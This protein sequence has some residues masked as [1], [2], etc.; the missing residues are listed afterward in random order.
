MGVLIE[1]STGWGNGMVSG[2]AS[3]LDD[4]G[5]SWNVFLEP[6]GKFEPL[7]IPKGWNGDGI[8]ARVN[9]AE[10]AEEILKAGI[11]CVNVS[12]YDYG[13]GTIAR[14]TLDEEESGR[15]A[16]KYY[17]NKKYSYFAYCG[18]PWRPD[19]EDLFGR[20]Y[21]QYLQT[22][23]YTC[24]T[25]PAPG[26]D[27]QQ[28]WIDQL[29]QL[30]TWLTKL[31]KPCGVLAIDTQTSRQLIDAAKF[32]ELG[33]PETIAVLAGE[34]DELASGI[35]RPK[36]SMLDNA[37]HSVGYN[38]A[39]LL[40]RIMR[41]EANR[42]ELVTIKPTNV[43]SKKSTDWTVLSDE[44]LMRALR[45]VRDNFHHPIQVADLAEQAGISRRLLEQLFDR[46]LEITPSKQILLVRLDEAKHLLDRSVLAMSEI[47]SRCGFDS[48]EVM[49]RAFQREL[50]LSPTK[51]RQTRR[52]G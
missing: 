46:H 47:A 7:H 38:A 12:W 26:I 5:E 45:F 36:L 39:Q 2:I 30:G 13:E 50:Q 14:C 3:Y 28:P 25:Y 9:N 21:S 48:P 6:R 29:R 49:C 34:H 32:A 4:C 8:I 40:D 41:G 24:H 44:R 22:A 27:R 31:P 43:I 20:A 37:A 35:T 1:T 10:L 16:A 19:Y 51:Y 52:G 15:L 18:S 23:G 33:V 42:G 17:L 11:P